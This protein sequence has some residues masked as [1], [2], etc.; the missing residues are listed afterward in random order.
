MAQISGSF[1]L[2]GIAASFA[3]SPELA[4]ARA[5]DLDGGLQSVAALT[6]DAQIALFAVL[7]G[8]AHLSRILIRDPDWSQWLA[9]NMAGSEP[10]PEL[11]A[12]ELLAVPEQSAALLRRWRQRSMLRIATRDL[13][14]MAPVRETLVELS[15][16]AE[17]A[18]TVATRLARAE[19]EREHGLIFDVQG[20]PARFV[21]LGL[22]K[23]G[24]RELNY[25]SDVDLVFIHDGGGQESRG[26]PKGGLEARA[27]FTR[28]AERIT[29]LLSEVQ[30]EG[31][32]FRVDL[33]LRPDGRNGPLTTSREA[34]L[35]YYETYGQSWERAAFFKA[36]PVGGDLELGVELL[37]ELASFIYRHALDYSMI[38]DL[39]NMKAQVEGEAR[40]RGD[41]ERDVKLGPGG[42]REVEFFAQSFSMVHGGLDPRLREPGCLALLGVLEEV[43][44]LPAAEAAALGAAYRWLRRVEHAVQ[45]QD[46][47]Q[48]HSIPAAD[49]ERRVVARRLACHL[50]GRGPIWRRAPVDGDLETFDTLHA[51]HTGTVRH[52]FADLFR[53]RRAEALSIADQRARELI[54][55]LD[56][57]AAATRAAALGFAEP[58]AAVDSL[59]LLRDGGEVPSRSVDAERALR[60]L[61]PALLEAVLATPAP[62][63]ALGLLA[64]FLRR[65]G[66]Q[67]S[68]LSL[69]AENRATLRLLIRLF[70]TSEF[71]SHRLLAQPDLLDGLVRSD[72]AQPRKTRE[73]L[74][75]ELAGR[76]AAAQGGE[77]SLDALRR[78]HNDESLRIGINDS[79]GLLHWAAVSEQLSDLAETAIVGA[80]DLAREWRGRR[81]GIP[82]AAGL[83]VVAMG[84]L[85][86]RELNY[87]SDLDL[88]FV[89][90]ADPLASPALPGDALR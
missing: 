59:R 71:L 15:E 48:V 49:E 83:V 87:H 53:D 67:R 25:S 61:S 20:R 76:L 62:D 50:K 65:V 33:R 68:F 46:D 36:R 69:L 19:V 75:R 1:G 79:E 18:I 13:W 81:H 47:R 22:G 28:M 39:E 45:L 11:D 72:L 74:R 26:G 58:Q 5:A 57:D 42:I 3:A 34:T 82:E 52:A 43:G 51:H 90:G 6:R 10:M 8:S 60:E 16:M 40:R 9:R 21:V 7:G 86:S 4:V 29:R 78:F 44:H 2:I 56:G 54:D 27:F 37:T 30:D 24:A 55:S 14:G 89:H 80:Y 64:E 85:G 35:Q 41:V 73:D 12:A 77:A 70:A 63:R 38:A 32:V 84:R 66:A 23:L 88:I 31:F 17:R